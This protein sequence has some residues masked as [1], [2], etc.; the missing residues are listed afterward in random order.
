MTG[1]GYFMWGWE[2]VL[3]SKPALERK[4]VLLYYFSIQHEHNARAS[5][6]TIFVVIVDFLKI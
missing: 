2:G 4:R 6:G 1:S 5:G 3:K